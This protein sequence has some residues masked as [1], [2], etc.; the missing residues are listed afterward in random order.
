MQ[1]A[2]LLI[3]LQKDYFPGGK[4]ELFEADRCAAQAAWALNLFRRRGL[5]AVFVQHV[6]LGEDASFFLPGS[7]GVQLHDALC[8]SGA[9]PTI[10]KHFPD[11][12]QQTDLQE[13]LQAL[14]IDRL[15]ICGMMSHMCV[16]TTV[17]AAFRLGYGVTVLDD[18]CTTKD[19]LWKGERIAAPTV[20]RTFMASLHGTFARVIDTDGLEGVMDSL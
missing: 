17:R 13:R 4:N 11:S 20:H 5:P 16:D 19:L 12:F 8:P 9:E 3:D 7:Q 18:A 6:S 10:V 2:L 1:T 14:S 15:V